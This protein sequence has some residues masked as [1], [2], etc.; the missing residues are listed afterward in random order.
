[1]LLSA[2]GGEA[3]LSKVNLDLPALKFLRYS[4]SEENCKSYFLRHR[5]VL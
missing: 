3:Q 2:R 4:F 1:M 5:G